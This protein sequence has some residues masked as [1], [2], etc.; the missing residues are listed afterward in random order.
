MENF[1]ATLFYFN[2]HTAHD[3]YY[4]KTVSISLKKIKLLAIKS[5][6]GGRFKA[7][8]IDKKFYKLTS[9]SMNGDFDKY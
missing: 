9:P 5:L 2:A 8:V 6:S 7:C 3:E 4:Y 1:Y